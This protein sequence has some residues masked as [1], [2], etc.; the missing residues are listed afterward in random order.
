MK[1]SLPARNR[2][3]SRRKVISLDATEFIK[4]QYPTKLPISMITA[5]SKLYSKTKP[6]P[7]DNK[8]L[9]RFS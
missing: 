6:I 5:I 9:K 8:I 2:S 4:K 7:Q 3:R 1:K